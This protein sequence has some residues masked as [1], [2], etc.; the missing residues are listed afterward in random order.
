MQVVR[1]KTGR[2]RAP[3]DFD[4]MFS[5]IALELRQ[6]AALGCNLVLAHVV[7][8]EQLERY[9]ALFWELE[10]IYSTVFLR[11]RLETAIDRSKTRT[12]HTGVT[13]EVWVEHLHEAL[14]VEEAFLPPFTYTRQFSVNSGGIR[15]RNPRASRAQSR[16]T[17]V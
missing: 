16:R 3:D 9:L 1:H 15:R 5:E 10:L 7:L 6:L 11:P 17:A 13:P 14:A 2:Q 12:C 8:P 4:V